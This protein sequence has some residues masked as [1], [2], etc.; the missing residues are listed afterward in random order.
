MLFRPLP[1]LS[2][3]H[4]S[5][6]E[7]IAIA[8]SLFTFPCSVIRSRKNAASTTT[9]D[10]YKR[11]VLNCVSRGRVEA[12]DEGQAGGIAGLS[13]SVIRGCAAQADLSGGDH[14]GGIVGQG[15]DIYDCV[16][17]TRIDSQ[18]EK[19]GAIAGSADSRS[20]LEEANAALD[21][22]ADN[23]TEEDGV[24][25]NNRFLQEA[26]AGVDGV[27]YSGQTEGLSYE[28]FS[29]LENV[30]AEFLDLAVTFV[31]NLSLIHI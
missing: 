14:L 11:Q 26:L 13:R 23:G 12:D 27:T 29:A 7:I 18:G 16:A 1:G 28:A 10:V 20:F 17:M 31:S 25:Q 15:R 5:L 24:V 19:L 21:G 30:P 4:I 22:E 6:A 2:L 9:G 3:I 8:A